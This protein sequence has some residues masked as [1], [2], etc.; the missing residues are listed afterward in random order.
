MET[1]TFEQRERALHSI[2]AF[3]DLINFRGGKANFARVHHE[4]GEFLTVPQK[5][6]RAFDNLRRLIMLPRGHLKSTVSSV[7]Y[8]LWRIYRNPDIRIITGTNTKRLSKGFIRELRQYLEDDW[9]QK[10]VWN[11][12][13]HISGTLIP[14]LSAADRRKR[15]AANSYGDETEDNEAVDKRLIWSSES[16]QVIRPTVMKEPTVQSMSVGTVLTGDHYDLAIL[17]DI[18]DFKNSDTKDKAENILDWT[19]DL[20]SIID[21]RRKAEYIYYSPVSKQHIRFVDWVGDEVVVLGTRYYKHDY[22]GYLIENQPE[23]DLSVFE[24]NVYRN[25]KNSKDGYTWEERFSDEVVRSIQKKLKSHRRF[26]SQYLNRIITDEEQV[27]KMEQVNWLLPAHIDIQPGLTQVKRPD[28]K[29]VKIRPII[30]VDPAASTHRVNDR[31]AIAVGGIDED[32]NLFILTWA[33]DYWNSRDITKKVYELAEKYGTSRVYV[34]R[35]GVGA[36]LPDIIKDASKEYKRAL[37]VIDHYA[38]GDKV[39][40]I[41]SVLEGYWS[42]GKIYLPQWSTGRPYFVDE[43]N[44]FPAAGGS[45][46]ILDA[47][48]DVATFS[49]PAKAQATRKTNKYRNAIYGGTR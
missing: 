18:V 22:Y 9:L 26:A 15:R 46:D 33:A 36:Y 25:G 1:P 21:P 10:N 42:T 14:A 19:R 40:R 16:L 28:G 49:V 11:N 8:T 27:F 29:T 44:E 20:E 4:L 34:E 24:R 41:T 3:A 5:Q 12:R 45:D 2:W 13:P 37:Y 30:C 23:L 47:F 39:T 32:M 31:T 38:K 35:N 7:L 48:E 43:V 17:D 6:S